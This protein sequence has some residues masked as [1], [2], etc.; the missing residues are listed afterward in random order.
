MPQPFW[1]WVGAPL[2]VFLAVL[3]CDVS[4]R[5]PSQTDSSGGV[6]EARPSLTGDVLYVCSDTSKERVTHRI[7]LPSGK[8][9]VVTRDRDDWQLGSADTIDSAAREALQVAF[10]KHRF[11]ALPPRLESAEQDGRSWDVRASSATK[12]H[13]SYNYENPDPDYR[14][15]FEACSHAFASVATRQADQSAARA[16]L[17]QVRGHLSLLSASDPRRQMLEDWLSE[18]QP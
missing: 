6:V 10:T 11:L 3:A 16:T 5:G 1:A 17:Q 15:V 14:A 4:P 8:A 9:Y 7:L 2:G 12:A 13:R 18:V